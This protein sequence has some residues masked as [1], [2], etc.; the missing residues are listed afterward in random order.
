MYAAYKASPESVHVSWRSVFAAMD[1]GVPAGAIF[2]PPP[3][4]NAGATLTSAAVAPADAAAA[5]DHVKVMQLVQ[6]FQSRGHNICDLDPLGMYDADLDGSMPPELELASYGF[7]EADLDKEFNLS[8]LQGAGFLAQDRGPVKLRTIY[9]R[10]KETYASKVGIEYMHLWDTEQVNWLRDK[11][12]TPSDQVYQYSAAERQVIFE[13][14]AKA[15]HF[16]AFLASKFSLAKRFGLEG[17]EVTIPGLEEMINVAVD[18]GVEN[19]VLGMAHRGRLNV[20]ANV[21]QKPLEQ[22]FAEFQGNAMPDEDSPDF[23]GSGD[24]KYHLGMSQT[25]TMPCGKDVH[26]SLVANPSHLECVNPVVSGKARAKQHYTGD[27]E[28]AKTMPILLHGDAA[29]SGQ[30]VVFETVGLSDLYNYTTGGTIHIVTNNQIGFT[31]DPRM[32]RST[33]YCT[34]VAKAVQAPIFHVNGD[35]VEAVVR[36]CRLAAEWR[37]TFKKDVVID[38]VGYRKHGHNEIDEPMFTQP[39]MYTAIKNKVGTFALYA[40]ECVSKGLLSQA[41]ADSKSAEV[42]A[43]LQEKLD[44]SRSF[45][46]DKLDWLANNWKGMLPPSSE[47]PDLLTGVEKDTLLELGRAISKLPDGFTPHRNIKKVYT[48]RAKMCEEGKGFDWAMGEQL[49]WASLLKEGNHVRISGQDVERGTFSHRHCV[50]HD[51]K[52]WGTKY[53]ALNN[54]DPGQAAFMACNS[55]LSEFGVLGFELGYALEN[56]ASLIMWEA[57]FGDFANTAQCMIDQF[58]SSG[59]QKW[60]RQVGLV[61]MLPHGYEGQGP[62]HSSARLERFL[63]MCDDDEDDVQVIG[64]QKQAQAANWAVVNVTT[65]ANYFHVLRRQVVRDFRKPLVV[66]SPKSLL[67]HKLVKSDIEDFAVG[68]RFHRYLP[69]A[70][71]ALKAPDQIRK[72][73]LCTGKV[74]YDVLAEREKR[75]VTDVAIGRL[76][77]ISPFPHDHLLEEAKKYPNAEIVWCQ[78]EQ[79]N[80]GAWTYVRPRISTAMKEVRDVKPVYAGRAAAAATASGHAKV[81]AAEQAALV[82]EALA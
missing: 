69:D 46:M 6:A 53:C 27:T 76:E 47:A 70:S 25:R 7:T 45:K 39:Q 71:P 58:I 66:M 38:I 68:S 33:P 4:I 63:Q 81:S 16:E 35:D 41:E 32:S 80:M 18:R 57:Q 5:Q 59:E 56:P 36:V 34:D 73:V 61:M 8:T 54:I 12:E 49:A 24:V 20:L 9:D 74:Y 10:L 82:D 77:Q 75:G 44:A 62:E 15:D 28:R 2:T 30:G 22:V 78:E 64:R 14:M 23:S 37:Q 31:T 43:T 11:I 52:E 26:I 13:N 48:Q 55:S 1:K 42:M 17:L 29:F 60:L 51:Q 40:A 72:L 67:R 3:T 19:V 79:K 21:C 50:I 65:P